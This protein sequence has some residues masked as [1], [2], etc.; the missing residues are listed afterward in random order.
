MMDREVTLLPHPD[1]PTIPWISPRQTEM[2]TPLTAGTT[3]LEVKKEVL[4]FSRESS[5]S[6]DFMS[7]FLLA[8]H[9]FM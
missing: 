6:L 7:F 8:A 2:E 1:S 3:P 4:R 9:C 5:V